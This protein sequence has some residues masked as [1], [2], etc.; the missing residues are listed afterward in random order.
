[1]TVPAFWCLALAL[2]SRRGGSR[3]K[4]SAAVLSPAPWVRSRLE[5]SLVR[6]PLRPW[7]HRHRTHRR[8]PKKRGGGMGGC[9][10]VSRDQKKWREMASRR[11]KYYCGTRQ[12]GKCCGRILRSIPKQATYRNT[13][14]SPTTAPE[15]CCFSG[16]GGSISPHCFA[17]HFPP[18]LPN[19]A[20]LLI[21]AVVETC[22]PP[23][24]R[25][26]NVT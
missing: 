16:G 11:A 21:A 5:H 25:R 3:Q 22:T 19:K 4:E 10:R 7:G 2:I 13:C 1:M 17:A 12:R 20:A 23:L 18:V 26:N 24:H 14:P 8:S 6:E 15:W 9:I